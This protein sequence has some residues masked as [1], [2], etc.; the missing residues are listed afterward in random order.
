MRHGV[1]LVFVLTTYALAP[2]LGFAWILTILALATLPATARRFRATYTAV[3]VI[4]LLYQ[5][6]FR[7]LL[8]DLLQ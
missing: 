7:P 2:V 8:L 6:P 3:F 5:L 1:M 4:L